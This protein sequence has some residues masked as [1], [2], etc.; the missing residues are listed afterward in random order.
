M[1]PFFLF[2][3]AAPNKPPGE[4]A[5]LLQP[6]ASSAQ[7]RA[8]NTKGG[9]KEEREREREREREHVSEKE[10]RGREGA[11]VRWREELDRACE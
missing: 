2:L 4:V 1:F 10:E 9:S 7:K 8:G 11:R 3:S 5:L 6:D